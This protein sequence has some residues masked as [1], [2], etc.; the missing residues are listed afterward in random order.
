MHAASV[1]FFK[2]KWFAGNLFRF[3]CLHILADD[4]K[5]LNSQTVRNLFTNLDALC[6]SKA[7][8]HEQENE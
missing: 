3:F 2:K 5:C 6:H 8:E 4:D 7:K 1:Y